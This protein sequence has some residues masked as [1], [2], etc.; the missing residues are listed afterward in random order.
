MSRVAAARPHGAAPAQAPR[1]RGGAG[2]IL[3]A[4]ARPRAAARAA[5]AAPVSARPPA[6]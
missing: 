5:R 4:F 1:R 3:R 2:L 6:A